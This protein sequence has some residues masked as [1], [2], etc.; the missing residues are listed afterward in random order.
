MHLILVAWLYVTLLVA[1]TEPTVVGAVM[2]F[3]FYGLLPSALIAY[4]G[5]TG[6]RKKRRR[7]KE[8][9][10]G[11]TDEAPPGEGAPGDGRSG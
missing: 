6:Q 9:A 5:G 11:E 3:V 2:S 10:G 1:A 4:I 7:L 8:A